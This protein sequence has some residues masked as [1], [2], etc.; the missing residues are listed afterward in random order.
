MIGK[1]EDDPKEYGFPSQL[2]IH[3]QQRQPWNFYN[4]HN[5]PLYINILS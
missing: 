2:L 1:F 5:N 3:D 4:M